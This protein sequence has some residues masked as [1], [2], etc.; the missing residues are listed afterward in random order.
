MK[1]KD[2]KREGLGYNIVETLDGKACVLTAEA[3]FFFKD[4]LGLP[5]ESLVTLIHDHNRANYDADSDT[6]ANFWSADINGYRRLEAES[7]P[8]R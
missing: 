3:V 5:V 1:I 4:S 6:Y 8:T 2:L 7:K